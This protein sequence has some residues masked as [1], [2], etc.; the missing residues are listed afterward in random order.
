MSATNKAVAKLNWLAHQL[1][2]IE[3]HGL[4][5]I[6]DEA[7]RAEWAVNSYRAERASDLMMGLALTA[8]NLDTSGLRHYRYVQSNVYRPYNPS[9]M[10]VVFAFTH[11][12]GLCQQIC[13][14]TGTT[15][16]QLESLGDLE[17]IGIQRR[18]L[19]LY[20][21][22][23]GSKHATLDT[24]DQTKVWMNTTSDDIRSFIR[25]LIAALDHRRL[26]EG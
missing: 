11:G 18:M 1:R 19:A 12:G 2:K 17:K 10:H 4:V 26:R 9:Y 15:P 21:M 5:L 25:G 14:K 23:Y 20:A 16:E 7:E 22:A 3:V 24:R 8:G 6:L 13:Q